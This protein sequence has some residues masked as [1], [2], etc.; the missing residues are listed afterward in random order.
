MLLLWLGYLVCTGLIVNSGIKLA[1]YGDIIAEKLQLGRVWLGMVLLATVTSLPE[2]I[3]GI[4]SVA[5]VDAPD[6]AVGNVLGSN[7]L[8]M[9]ILALLDALHSPAPISSKA[10]RGHVLSA[11]FSMLLLGITAMSLFVGQ[12]FYP[13]DWIGSYSFVIAALYFIS[14]KAVYIFEKR[15]ISEFVAE[16]AQ[17][18]KYMKIPMKKALLHFSIN[19]GV[20][21]AAAM[22]LPELGEELA[23]RTSL[24]QIFIGSVLI[25]FSTALPELV[26]SVSAMK[27]GSLDLAVGNLFGSIIFN[28]FILAID[29]VFFMAGPILSYA[30]RGHLISAISGILMVS[31]AVIGLTFR[32]AR[33]RLILSWDSIGIVFVYLMNVFLLYKVR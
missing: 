10:H 7:L 3:T 19:G 1:K 6:I 30:G 23:D 2:L 12:Y 5:I 16:M 8:N 28:I 11:G 18:L 24:G 13:V 9:L 4:S 33:K 22:L 32:A 21:V 27:M 15:E 25:S 17:E 29:D 20:V 14:V 31:L 26:V